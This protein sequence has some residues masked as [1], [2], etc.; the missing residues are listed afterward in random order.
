[1]L[2]IG[3]LSAAC[4][5]TMLLATPTKADRATTAQSK[6]G[7]LLRDDRGVRIDPDGG[8]PLSAACSDARRSRLVIGRRGA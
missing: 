1:M 5:A 7:D 8:L 4:A 3:V 6:V 2:V